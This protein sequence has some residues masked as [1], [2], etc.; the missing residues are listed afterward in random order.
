MLKN[1]SHKSS[2]LRSLG[3]NFALTLYLVGDSGK[4][5]QDTR[6]KVGKILGEKWARKK[7]KILPSNP[8]ATTV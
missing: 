8:Y 3:Y 2:L 1:F 5:G 6:G 7:G 4:V